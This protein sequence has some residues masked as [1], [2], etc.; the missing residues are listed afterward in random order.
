MFVFSF[1]NY[2]IYHMD[3]K[4]NLNDVLISLS[5]RKREIKKKKHETVLKQR[6]EEAVK[7]RDEEK[8]VEKLILE[9]IKKQGKFDFSQSNQMTKDIIMVVDLVEDTDTDFTNAINKLD[10]IDL[11]RMILVRD[12]EKYRNGTLTL[13]ELHKSVNK[14]LKAV[15][16]DG[17]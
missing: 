7:L 6:Y 10:K 4:L 11:E 1:Y 3:S 8:E 14:S 16:N 9:E 5:A 17:R 12:I 2:Y 13:D 15:N